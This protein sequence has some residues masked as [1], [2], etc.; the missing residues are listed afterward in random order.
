MLF[1]N[2]K[3]IHSSSIISY[4]LN[5]KS[6]NLS[7][8]IIVRSNS[9]KKVDR[10]KFPVL[11]EKDLEE[12]FVKGSGPGG[13]NVN[14]RINCCFLK[15]APTSRHP[16]K[17]YHFFN[18]IL[19]IYEFTDLFVKCHEQR[20]LESN[21]KKARKLLLIKLDNHLNG[22]NSVEAQKKRIELELQKRSNDQL[23]LRRE[24]KLKL[25]EYLKSLKKKEEPANQEEE[26]DNSKNIELIKQLDRLN[27]V[28]KTKED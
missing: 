25:K 14:K 6:I 2:L 16:F 15:H 5:H 11:N 23:K 17:Y 21:R 1:Q 24:K 19:L 26:V 18:L 9:S 13:Q 22:E 3:L 28:N 12:H 8:S 27:Q 7:H 4:L 10:S 20:E